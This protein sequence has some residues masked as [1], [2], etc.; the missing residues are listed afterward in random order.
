MKPPKIYLSLFLIVF[1]FILPRCTNEDTPAGSPDNETFIS[2]ALK[3]SDG[4]NQ[5]T[6]LGED[7]VTELR[8]LVFDQNGNTAYNAMLNF[9]NGFSGSSS[10]IKFLPGTYDF[11]F[12]AN[13]SAY[14]GF[15]SALN[16][17]TNLSQFQSNPAF[18]QLEYDPGFTPDNSSLAGRFLMSAVY[19]GIE[20]FQ[21]GSQTDPHPLVLPTSGVELVR[22]LAKVE[23][24]FRKK[25]PG[26][27]IPA[28]S[29]IE[30][31]R[32]QKVAK[33]Y[34]LPPQDNFY[35]GETTVSSNI[36]NGNFDYTKDSI[37][38]IVFYIPEFL[39]QAGGTSFTELNINGKIFPIQSDG[40]KIGL[41]YQRRNI[42]SLSN[43]SV[44]R[45]YH[46][47]IDVLL[48][49]QGGIQLQTNIAIWNKDSYMFIL[50]DQGNVA[51]FPPVYKSDSTIIIPTNCGRIEMRSNNEILSQGLMGGYGDEV[52][53]WDPVIQGPLP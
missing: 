44:I 32:L 52:N 6:E 48:N 49:S 37:G 33:Y 17:L 31:V 13:E 46:Y 12:I 19:K 45:N 27:T 10:A 38:A 20:V 41:A 14:T 35:T 28:G 2:M 24:I 29:G 50:Q 51:V 3:A 39:N 16:S 4:I 36:T 47:V 5:D 34:S 25:S 30:S 15:T 1:I 42:A 40:A 22:S 8:M 18:S 43:N 53:W 9:P 7:R 23:V 21:G 26:A 11:Y